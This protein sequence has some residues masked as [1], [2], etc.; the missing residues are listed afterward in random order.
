MTWACVKPALGSSEVIANPLS[1]PKASSASAAP[2]AAAQEDL[3]YFPLAS[4]QDVTVAGAA[5]EEESVAWGRP[6][7]LSEIESDKDYSQYDTRDKRDG[8]SPI[9]RRRDP[10]RKR[11][12]PQGRLIAQEISPPSE[13]E[14]RVHGNATR[15]Q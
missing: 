10:H 5:S 1:L 11:N 6:C 3:R 13:F 8:G 2:E 4:D 7:V 14:H 15:D 9:Q 12:F